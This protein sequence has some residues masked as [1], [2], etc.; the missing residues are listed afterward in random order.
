MVYSSVS[1][2]PITQTDRSNRSF[3]NSSP[4]HHHSPNPPMAD[5][6]ALALGD[7]TVPNLNAAYSAGAELRY[8]TVLT[9]RANPEMQWPPLPP[10]LLLIFQNIIDGQTRLQT[11][12]QNLPIQLHTQLQEPM[13]QLQ[14]RIT[15]LQTQLQ[16]GITQ[17]R[18]GITQI[19]EGNQLHTQFQEGVTPLHGSLNQLDMKVDTFIQ[20]GSS[21]EVGSSSISRKRSKRK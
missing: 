1:H 16:E 19:Q 8:S 15:Q 17:L 6:P 9:R 11:Q 10:E 4:S 7:S 12:L 5:L 3:P 21:Q 2:S 20:M 13:T 18:E 14:E